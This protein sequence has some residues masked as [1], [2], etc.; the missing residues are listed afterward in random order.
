MEPAVD[1]W[2]LSAFA[3]SDV[4]IVDKA[5]GLKARRSDTHLP[6]RIRCLHS[7]RILTDDICCDALAALRNFSVTLFEQLLH[8]CDLLSLYLRRARIL[9]PQA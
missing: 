6:V 1:G 4:V 3:I 5:G 9:L 7:E 2:R 8:P